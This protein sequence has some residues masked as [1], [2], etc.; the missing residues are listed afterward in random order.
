MTGNCERTRRKHFRDGSRIF[1]TGFWQV[2]TP[3][4]TNVIVPDIALD[5]YKKVRQWSEDVSDFRMA[6]RGGAN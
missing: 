6:E 3:E 2:K 4:R 1:A 5:V